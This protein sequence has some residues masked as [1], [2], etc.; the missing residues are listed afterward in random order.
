MLIAKSLL[1]DIC[2]YLGPYCTNCIGAK[3]SVFS[4]TVTYIVLHLVLPVCRILLW[5][6]T[7]FRMK[8]KTYPSAFLRHHHAKAMLSVNSKKGKGK[9]FTDERD[10]VCLPKQ[11]QKHSDVIQIPRKKEMRHFLAV[12]KLVGK[13][14]LSSDMEE[15]EIFDEI[16]SVFHVP[17]DND[18]DFSFKILQPSG[19]DSRS[20]I[21]PE[22]P[23]PTSGVLVL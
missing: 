3:W 7:H 21:I 19:G 2:S 17:M 4:D 22:L 12:N 18:I 15:I 5:C 14:L 9:M 10:I 1:R 8:S 13:I 6:L 20:L 16:Q 23:I 11:C